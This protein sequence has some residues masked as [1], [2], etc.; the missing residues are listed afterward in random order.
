MLRHWG[1]RKTRGFPPVLRPPNLLQGCSITVSA[2]VLDSLF[3]N[4]LHDILL[5]RPI[6][7]VVCKRS[8]ASPSSRCA[9]TPDPHSMASARGARPSD[10]ECSKMD[11]ALSTYIALLESHGLAADAR[12]EVRPEG[13]GNAWLPARVRKLKDA[14]VA[15]AGRLL[16]ERKV[17]VMLRMAEGDK[18]KTIEV[19]LKADYVRSASSEAGSVG[20][21][22]ALESRS[23]EGEREAKRA[24]PAAGDCKPPAKPVETVDLTALSDGE[25]AK[26]SIKNGPAARTGAGGNA[27]LEARI[28][29]LEALERV[30]AER[31]ELETEAAGLLTAKEAAETRADASLR[32]ADAAEKEAA[33]ARAEGQRLATEA[34]FRKTALEASVAE[35]G[36]LHAAH[37]ADRAELGKLSEDLRKRDEEIDV[38]KKRAEAIEDEA[39]QAKAEQRALKLRA[40]AADLRAGS[41]DQVVAAK[42][43]FEEQI[44]E[45]G[46]SLETVLRQADGSIAELQRT[47]AAQAAQQIAALEATKAALAVRAADAEVRAEKAE[48]RVRELEALQVGKPTELRPI[49]ER[50]AAAE[51]TPKPK[52][53]GAEVAEANAGAADAGKQPFKVLALVRHDVEVSWRGTGAAVLPADVQANL[54]RPNFQQ[55]LRNFAARFNGSERIF[56]YNIVPDRAAA[57]LKAARQKFQGLWPQSPGPIAMP[58]APKRIKIKVAVAAGAAAAPRAPHDAEATPNELVDTELDTPPQA[59]QVTP[60][61][62]FDLERSWPLSCAT[63]VPADIL[64]TFQMRSFSRK[65]LAFAKQFNAGDTERGSRIPRD[66]AVAF[67]EAVRHPRRLQRSRA[68]APWFAKGTRTR[69]EWARALRAGRCR[70]SRYQAPWREAPPRCRM[71]LRRR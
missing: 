62:R 21:K 52:A 32:R 12:A 6:G 65:L 25:D 44:R 45:L 43:S 67:L 54:R 60:L 15:H 18:P 53:A 56:S 9:R 42:I 59:Y 23:P 11:D 13:K 69:W 1:H 41:W 4:A 29:E 20:Q 5:W 50:N 34:V 61:V 64:T 68:P 16:R 8:K 10:A 70:R 57:F 55:N 30:M 47:E 31:D 27:A 26:K 38:L 22:R 7:W 51:R 40:D 63:L 35:V 24:R 3:R 49:K 36:K 17:R 58:R 33:A 48:R 14:A 19:P 71:P 37:E 2:H 66:R 46:G 39:R 28:R